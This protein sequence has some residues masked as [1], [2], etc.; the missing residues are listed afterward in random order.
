MRDQFATRDGDD[1]VIRIPFERIEEILADAGNLSMLS[2][3]VSIEDKD[4][5][6]SQLIA[7]I[8]RTNTVESM[9]T[10]EVDAMREQKSR[11]IKVH[12]VSKRRAA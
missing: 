10:C 2:D 8:N 4:S 11:S 1:I 6:L 7:Q 12:G 5:F 9:L 3:P